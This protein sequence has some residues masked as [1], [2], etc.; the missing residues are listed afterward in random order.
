MSDPIREDLVAHL[1]EQIERDPLAYANDAKLRAALRSMLD[2][3]DIRAALRSH[4]ED[5]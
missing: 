3:D 5:E 2:L 4:E 1:R